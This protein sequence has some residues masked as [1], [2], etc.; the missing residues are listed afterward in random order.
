MFVD[1]AAP[2]EHRF[3]AAEGGGQEPRLLEHADR[4]AIG[5]DIPL[6]RGGRD[7]LEVG[8]GAAVAAHAVV[9]GQ[10]LGDQARPD[11]ERR[12]MTGGG[13][14]SARRL[15]QDLALERI[16]R[17]RGARN[18]R[19]E[20]RAPV[21]ACEHRGQHEGSWR[22]GEPGVLDGPPELLGGGVRRH[23]DRAAQDVGERAR[24]G[25]ID[26]DAPERREV[27][28]AHEPGQPRRDHGAAGFRK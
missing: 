5:V 14:R 12:R 6:E 20:R 7:A 8:D 18:G 28:H 10:H 15:E 24:D 9:E 19:V 11:R 16:H 26:Q 1:D 2:G 27:G 3:V 21:A 17:R 4:A 22:G 25:A 23:D 13:R